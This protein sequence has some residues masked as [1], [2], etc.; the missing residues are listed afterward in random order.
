MI[1]ERTTG[2][3]GVSERVLGGRS[4][5]HQAEASRFPHLNKEVRNA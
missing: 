2:F 3:A 1:R 4:I 5:R